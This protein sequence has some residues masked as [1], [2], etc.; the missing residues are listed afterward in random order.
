MIA[1]VNFVTE[2]VNHTFVVD[3]SL[4]EGP[5]VTTTHL[6][7]VYQAVLSKW[8]PISPKYGRN[9]TVR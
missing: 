1:Y 4:K 3:E 7:D 2:D 9:W 5:I 8:F 6:N